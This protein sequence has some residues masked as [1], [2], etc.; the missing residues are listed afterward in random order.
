[1]DGVEYLKDVFEALG[2]LLLDGEFRTAVCRLHGQD[3]LQFFEGYL[4]ADSMESDLRQS[5]CE[6]I[7]AKN[8]HLDGQTGAVFGCALTLVDGAVRTFDPTAG[9]VLSVV[10]FDITVD[11]VIYATQQVTVA[12]GEFQVGDV[13][14]MAVPASGL[15]YDLPGLILLRE[16]KGLTS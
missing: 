3:S 7:I 16:L 9:G 4:S 13:F 8:M 15:P 14:T 11:E 2:D 6:S 10:A 5:A 12:A 1:V